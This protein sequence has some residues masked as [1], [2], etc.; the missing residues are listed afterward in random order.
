ML[1]TRW[2]GKNIVVMDQ[3][4]VMGPGYKSEDCKAGKE[5]GSALARVKKV[6]SRCFISGHRTA[7]QQSIEA[8]CA[9]GSKLLTTTTPIARKRT[10]ETCAAGAQGS[11]TRHTGC[12]C[13]S[14]FR[15]RTQEGRM[16]DINILNDQLDTSEG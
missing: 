7:K 3:V 10:Q 14:S 16:I 9:C 15:R 4:T 1:P 8:G 11:Q 5:A 13:H 6:V 12:A 2:E